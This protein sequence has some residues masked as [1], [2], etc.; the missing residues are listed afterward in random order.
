VV[1]DVGLQP[2]TSQYLSTRE[3]TSDRFPLSLGVCEG[4]GLVQLTTTM[5]LE[6]SV[7]PEWQNFIEPETHLSSLAEAVVR[8][9]SFSM[10]TRVCGVS[11][12]D[13]SLLQ[14]F[15]HQGLHGGEILEESGSKFHAVRGKYDLVVA[16]HIFEHS[17]DPWDF[18]GNMAQ[19]MTE[20][21]C[22]LLEVPDCEMA[23]QSLDYTMLWEDHILYFTPCTLR[24]YFGETVQVSWFERYTNGNEAYLTIVLRKRQGVGAPASI[25]REVLDREV[26]RANR[27]GRQFPVEKQ[28]I[29]TYLDREKAAGRKI[30]LFGAGHLGVTFLAVHGLEH[31]FTAVVDD[32]PMKRGR[33]FPG[34]HLEIVGSE[35]LSSSSNALCVLAMSFESERKVR[36]QHKELL[37]SGVEFYSLFPNGANRLPVWAEGV[38]FL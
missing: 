9:H 6:R 8:H 22:L 24:N 30:F 13:R 25:A 33:I 21:G 12:K 10:A 28:R 17:L 32:S 15:V 4:C 31:L 7:F 27:F 37:Q 5:P 16:R 35:I 36:E 29:T 38:E 1:L 14:H 19:I 18:L 20:E 3:E 23:L 11:Y 26:E 2:V 34:T